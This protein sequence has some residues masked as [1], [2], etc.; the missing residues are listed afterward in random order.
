MFS[1]RLLALLLFASG[2]VHPQQSDDLQKLRAMM[3]AMVSQEK[4]ATSLLQAKSMYCVFQDGS[5]TTWSEGKAV[6]EPDVMTKSGDP[7]IFHSI[8]L[9]ARTASM[10][11][12]M[13]SGP[14]TV[15]PTSSGIHFIEV[16][17]SGNVNFTTVF[18]GFAKPPKGFFAVHSRHFFASGQAR[19]SQYHGICTV[20]D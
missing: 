10:M 9:K 12:N 14:I 19:P 15:I 5:F 4:A 1:T 3:E 11:G 17:D 2:S 7:T 6:V 16:T 8:D 13:G 20:Q 18:A